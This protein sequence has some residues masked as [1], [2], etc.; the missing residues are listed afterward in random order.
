MK[1]ERPVSG[2]GWAGCSYPAW[3]LLSAIVGSFGMLGY[4]PGLLAEWVPDWLAVGVLVLP[5]VLIVA[6][7]WGDAPD[8]VVSAIHLVAGV[9]FIVAVVGWR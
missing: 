4:Y 2:L 5:V 6:V 3:M 8:R 1:Q 9:L 7:Q